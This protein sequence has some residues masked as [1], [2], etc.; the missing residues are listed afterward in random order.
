MILCDPCGD[1]LG[2]R[3]KN[4][5]RNQTN[6]N[7]RVPKMQSQNAGSFFGCCISIR[8]GASFLW[9]HEIINKM[10]TCSQTEYLGPWKGVVWSDT[11]VFNDWL[12]NLVTAPPPQIPLPAW[13]SNDKWGG[14]KKGVGGKMGGWSEEPHW[15]REGPANSPPPRLYLCT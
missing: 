9:G 11:C 15:E 3:F 7:A 10:S 8:R 13:G 2:D 1:G 12:G 5:T 4:E 6:P 14:G